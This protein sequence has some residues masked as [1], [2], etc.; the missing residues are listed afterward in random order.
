MQFE[1]EIEFNWI[2]L[3]YN[4][5]PVSFRL[6]Y[7]SLQPWSLDNYNIPLH[8][9]DTDTSSNEISPWVPVPTMPSKVSWKNRCAVNNN[10]FTFFYFTLL[11]TYITERN[12]IN[13][14]SLIQFTHWHITYTYITR[15]HHINNEHWL[16]FRETCES[17]CDIIFFHI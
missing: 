5:C 9:S 10:C 15:S 1:F 4:L 7:W 3:S 11:I 17:N 12:S 14:L 8:P 2:I 6:P 16:Y 13:S